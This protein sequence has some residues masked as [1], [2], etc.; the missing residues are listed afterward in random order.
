MN[1]LILWGGLCLALLCGGCGEDPC[2]NLTCQNGGVCLDGTCD[3]PEG[4][5]GVNCELSLDP[6]LRQDCNPGSTAECVSNGSEARCVCEPGY[7][8]ARC[9]QQWTDK[10][11][12]R[13][14]VFETCGTSEEQ[15]FFAEVESGP[16]FQQITLTNFHNQASALTS[17]KV[18][19]D[20]VQ[21]QVGAITDQFMTFGKVDG[22]VNYLA[23]SELRLTYIIA[24]EPDTLVCVAT[25][26]PQ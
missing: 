4:F 8:G 5:T 20:L 12:G 13:F 24:T 19:A 16:R 14:E 7:E 21:G 9:Q 2:A 22:S 11:L 6:C 25:Y 3:C 17:A 26:V 18:V 15:V 1:H 10:F 23:T